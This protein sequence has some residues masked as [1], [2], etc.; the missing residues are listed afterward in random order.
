M[1]TLIAMTHHTIGIITYNA[2]VYSYN[3]NENIFLKEDENSFYLL[4]AFITDGS[5]N[6]NRVYLSSKD[7]LWLNDIKNLICK[8]LPLIKDGNNCYRLSIY[9]KQIRNWLLSHECIP[10]KSLIVK[11]PIVPEKYL[12]DFLRGC[13]DGD[14]SIS[15]KQYKRYRNKNGKPYLF[16]STHYTLTSASKD[17]I[18]AF[19]GVLLKKNF[20]HSII[21]NKPGS[22]ISVIDGRKIL[23][24][25]S[26]YTL[27]GGHKSAHNFL[28]WIYYPNH[29][30][31]LNRKKELAEK[32]IK[33]YEL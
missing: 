10:N 13:I 3:Y 18:T 27:S 23:H 7:N 12:P 20:N 16:Y 19:S 15:H 8:D 6:Q 14:G 17:F 11:F 21:E 32:I 24:K 30:I 22:K 9:N 1:L 25:H 29:N 5:I 31:S 33:F 4:G 26:I 28:Q 2:M